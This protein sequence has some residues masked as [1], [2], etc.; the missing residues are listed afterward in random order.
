M[1]IKCPDCGT[2]VSD[3]AAVCPRCGYPIQNLQRPTPPSGTQFS[4]PQANPPPPPLPTYTKPSSSPGHPT[5]TVSDSAVAFVLL[6][7]MIASFWLYIAATK[8]I[9]G[10]FIAVS[11]IAFAIYQIRAKKAGKWIISGFITA[12]ISI[13]FSIGGIVTSHQETKQ[14]TEQKIRAAKVQSE[15]QDAQKKADQILMQAKDAI[16]ANEIQKAI[17]LLKHARVI[18]LVDT[19]RIDALLKECENYLSPEG[20]I[21]TVF[22]QM[23]D[24]E[25]SKFLKDGTVPDYRFFENDDLQ[26]MFIEKVRQVNKNESAKM[27]TAELKRLKTEAEEQDRIRRQQEE[28]REA[29]LYQLE[30]SNWSWGESYGYAQATGQVKNTSGESLRNVQA[31][32]SFYDRNDTFITSADALIDYN[33]ILPGQSSPFKVME[34]YNPAMHSA[35]L[36]FKYFGGGGIT[37]RMKPKKR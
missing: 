30:V 33:P 32:V 31:V 26:K 9:F 27:R 36:E 37:S 35:R 8:P 24:Q 34:R 28:E 25:F 18:P 19:A 20:Q 13:L 1:L 15:K 5:P 2:E 29:R 10:L 22:V 12:I 17:D 4:S 3:Q 7:L 21:R 6:I 14:K 23:N 11:M 16:A